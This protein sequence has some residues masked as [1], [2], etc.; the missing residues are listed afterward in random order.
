MSERDTRLWGLDKP[1]WI[2]DNKVYNLTEFAHLHPGG[3][4]WIEMTKGQD[5]SVLFKT[6]HLDEEKARKVLS[7]YYVGEAKVKHEPRFDFEETGHYAEIRKRILSKF[8]VK[9]LQDSTSTD[10]VCLTYVIS[11]F[12]L[13]SLASYLHSYI[14]SIA[15]GLLMLGLYGIGHLYIHRKDQNNFLK[16]AYLLSGF[17]SREQKIMHVF[18]HHPY[19]NTALDY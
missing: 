17:S 16:S 2:C 6:H 5:I 9:E 8:S 13:L 10:K 14:L 18:S 3:S 4:S 19:V 7:E 15:C 1:L 11:W 12:T